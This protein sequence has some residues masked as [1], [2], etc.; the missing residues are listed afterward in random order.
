MMQILGTRKRKCVFFIVISFLCRCRYMDLFISTRNRQIKFYYTHEGVVRSETFDVDMAP[1]EW[2]QVAITISGHEVTLH[3]DCEEARTVRI[4]QPDL[5]FD[6]R[7]LGIWLGQRGPTKALYKVI[8]LCK[9]YVLV[10]YFYCMLICCCDKNLRPISCNRFFS[11]L[12]I[13]HLPF[14]VRLSF[15]IET[16]SAINF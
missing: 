15:Q 3:L 10:Y 1:N 6:K 9:I 2:H 8:Y 5:T 16:F 12:S 7:G 13:W 11:L 4:P 14:T